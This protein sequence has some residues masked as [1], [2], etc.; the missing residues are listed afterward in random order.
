M[1]FIYSILAV[2]I[3]S[4][5]AFAQYP[6]TL[7]NTVT[8]SKEQHPANAPREKCY[9]IGD[10]LGGGIIFYL[11]ESG[12]HGLIS[13]KT[14]QHTNI[15]WGPYSDTKAYATCV[16]C[17]FGNTKNIVVSQGK[18]NYA[19]SVCFNLQLGEWP[20]VWYL[21]STY[22]LHLMYMNIG[23]GAAAPNTNKGNFANDNYW[24][25]SEN[26]NQNAWNYNFGNGYYSVGGK[27]EL[28]RVRAIR[29]F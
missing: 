18:G 5:S 19:A 13:T 12:C 3:L 11:D 2:F 28:F 4:T 6:K 27:Q 14:D 24:A 29:S 21:P 8:K 20:I 22:E 25:S 17:G 23:P 1:K 26:H 9:Q 10:E 16:G 15:Y 7:N